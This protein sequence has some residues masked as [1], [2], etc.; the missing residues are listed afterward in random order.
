MLGVLIAQLF[1]LQHTEDPDL[2]LGFFILGIPLA[3][4]C[5]AAAIVVILLGGFRF[6]RQQ[7]AILRG[8]IN[9]RGW[10]LVIVL[11]LVFLVSDSLLVISGLSDASR[12]CCPCSYLL[13]LR[14][15]EEVDRQGL[16]HNLYYEHNR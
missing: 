9:A 12:L 5:V 10:E 6:W 1:R 14:M 4:T 13:C 15:S 8:K 16:L 7:N 11:I 3:C 2:V